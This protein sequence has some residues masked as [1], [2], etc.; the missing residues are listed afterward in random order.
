MDRRSFIKQV[1]LW[2]AGYSL[3]IPHFRIVPE[4]L[5]ASAPT[6][7]LAFS[8]GSDYGAL[9][10]Q[11]L[12]PLGGIETFV[13]PGNKVVIKPNIGWDRN[14][15]QAANTHPLVVKALVEE[16]LAAGAKEVKIFDRTCNEERRCY[17]NSGIKKALE[18]IDD[19]R[20]KQFHPDDR[21]YVPVKIERG[22]SVNQLSLY[23][24]AL[25][26]D[27]YINVPIAKHHSLSTLSLGLKNS[28]GVLGGN[29]GWLHF[30]LGQK[31]A[32]LATVIKPELTIIDAT[33]ILLRNGPQGGNLKDV[34]ITNMLIASADAVAADAFATATLFKMKPEEI[35]S[36]AAA[37][38]MGLGEM[39]LD[40]MQIIKGV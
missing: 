2:S 36:T 21:K 11:V 40:A 26:A 31:L 7:L 10:R 17:V 1:F 39:R 22:K 35:A 28:M 29:R 25:E 13:K 20:V 3:A 23:R 18:E 12:K 9:A 33:R 16:A 8:E 24:D 4:A 30:N 15:D 5:A 14:P 37:Y 34:K 38:S 32:D 27:C 19:R 6:P